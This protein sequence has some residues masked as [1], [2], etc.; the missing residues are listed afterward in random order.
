MDT[1]KLSRSL[2]NKGILRRDYMDIETLF[3]L[4]ETAKLEGNRDK[5][6]CVMVELIKQIP[7]EDLRAILLEWAY[8]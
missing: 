3:N 1:I 6:A 4:A 7:P 5:L 8:M 2:P